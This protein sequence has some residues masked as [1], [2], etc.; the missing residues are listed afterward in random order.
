VLTAIEQLRAICRW[1]S[2]NSYRSRKTSLI[3]RMD[4]L[5]AGKRSSLNGGSLTGVECPAPPYACGKHSGMMSNTNSD[6]ARKTFGFVSESLFDIIPESCS[7]SSRNAVRLY[8]GI[9][10]ALPRIPQVTLRERQPIGRAS[11][12]TTRPV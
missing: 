6:I 8:P 2:F 7:E 11:G 4:V 9:V 3:F 1:S 5:L 12:I 10:F